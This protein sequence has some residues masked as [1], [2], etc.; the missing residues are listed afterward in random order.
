MSTQVEQIK[1]RLSIVDVVGSYVK[2]EKAGANYKARCPFHN[3]KTPSFFIS[4]ARNSYYCF[5]C[6]AKGDIFSFVEEFE[7]VDFMG[8][9]KVLAQRAGVELT[10]SD[11]KERSER[12][13]SFLALEYATVFYQKQLLE[14]P[15]YAKALKYLKGRGLTDETIKEW[16]IGYAPD[17]WRLLS[18]FLLGKRFTVSDLEKVGLVKRKDGMENKG[19][20]TEGEVYDRFRGRI[21]FPLFD[22]S[23]R[24]IGFSGRIFEG[25]EKTGAKYLNS[26]E[27][28]LF[29]KSHFL[30][31][32]HAAKM[33]IREKDAAVLVEGQMDLLMAH[34]SGMKN[35]VAVSGTAL[36][37]HHVELLRRLSNKLV[38]A[39][40]PD[41]AG[42][43]AAQR[44]AT[45]ALRMGV[46]VRVAELPKGKDPADFILEDMAGW[47]NV[48]TK[49][50]HI[51][52]FTLNHIAREVTDERQLIQAIR[53]KVLPFV[54]SLDS[55]MERSHFIGMISKKTGIKQ[56]AIMEDL[57]KVQATA[58]TQ[59]EPVRSMEVQKRQEKKPMLERK[60]LGI[61]YWQESLSDPVIK[62][63]KLRQ[64]LI[65]IMDEHSFNTVAAELKPHINELILEAEVSYEHSKKLQVVV[66]ELMVNLRED[67]LKRA[68]AETLKQLERAERTKDTEKIKQL[69]E[70]CKKIGEQIATLP[71]KR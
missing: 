54:A 14:N 62:P 43:A 38:M 56:E 46:E 18:G 31:G 35:T 39:F 5:G 1:E 67:Y 52:E 3:E 49:A 64:D 17:E 13:K 59:Q 60:I 30:Y 8:A 61:L 24:A 41:S 22:P 48:L 47:E 44:S 25:D 26:P 32:F 33:A 27:T 34:Q 19:H 36:T 57:S 20:V 58:V 28:E 9:L 55:S 51:I 23:G 42:V 29:S 69:L 66:D 11:P 63:D 68:F 40:D 50:V 10:K 15:K 70:Q 4:P 2:I 37:D 6:S 71:K 21:M 12:Q 7:G 45:I 53:I 16:R 65:E